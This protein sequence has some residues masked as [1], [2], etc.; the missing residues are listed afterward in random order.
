MKI[1]FYVLETGEILKNT[2]DYLVDKSGKV[3]KNVSEHDYVWEKCP[4]VGYRFVLNQ[5]GSGK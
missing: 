4:T 3:F 2:M 1:E 5:K